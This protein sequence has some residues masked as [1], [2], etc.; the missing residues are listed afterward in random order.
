MDTYLDTMANEVIRSHQ[1]GVLSDK[2][3][4]N[5][6]QH[7]SESPKSKKEEP[8]VLKR[9][10]TE[11]VELEKEVVIEEERHAD[12]DVNIHWPDMQQAVERQKRRSLRR[13]SSLTIDMTDSVLNFR[14]ED[15]NYSAETNHY[16][17]DHHA[18]TT[19]HTPTMS[20]LPTY[21]DGGVYPPEPWPTTWVP[22]HF[23]EH[24]YP[25]EHFRHSVSHALNEFGHDLVISGTGHTLNSPRVDC[26][27]SRTTYYFDIEL[28]GLDNTQDLKLRWIGAR[29]L[30][31]KALVKRKPTAEDEAEQP[32]NEESVAA[33]DGSSGG[34][35]AAAKQDQKVFLTLSER[36][37]GIYGRAFSFGVD[38]DHEKTTAK[39]EAGVL[40]LV[41]P[42]VQE[43]KKV[44]KTVTV[45]HEAN[46]AEVK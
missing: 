28:P 43:D 41:V 39:L 31:V 10:V 5:S 26:R 3:K 12:E 24:H 44:D 15:G 46:S 40:K 37:I 17:L 1:H 4:E 27:E 22:K 2:A 25:L 16:D 35:K 8:E 6:V 30:L 42:K 29:S 18:L 19:N 7:V 13:S 23:P 33:A 32:A 34:K 9:R 38:V 21:Y 45:D 20:V 11:P 14:D 36:R